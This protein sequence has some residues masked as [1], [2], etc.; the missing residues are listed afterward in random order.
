[1]GTFMDG[2]KRHLSIY[3][4][5]GNA[6]DLKPDTMINKQP[7]RRCWHKIVKR[8]RIALCKEAIYQLAPGAAPKAW[9]TAA[10][11]IDRSVGSSSGQWSV[12]TYASR[13]V[14]KN[15]KKAAEV[16]TNIGQ[17]KQL[18][19]E[20]EAGIEAG[21]VT[22]P[23]KKAV[24]KAAKKS[25]PRRQRGS[26]RKP[27]SRRPGVR[28]GIG[29]GAAHR[30]LKEY[31][32]DNPLSVGIKRKGAKAETE[33]DLPSGDRIDV[34]F[35][36]GTS[37]VGVEVKSEQSSEDDIRR[38]LYQCVKYRAVMEADCAV[39]NIEKNI[40]VLLALGGPFPQSLLREKTVL[41]IEVRDEMTVPN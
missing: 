13:L 24:S 33:K 30:T 27:G 34:F 15:K 39:R 31:I 35:E 11:N 10:E 38:G 7:A 21:D 32:R 40:R 25:G 1:M 36:N 4:H 17:I 3:S 9:E 2:L 22:R 12:E 20:L 6:F 14:V 5:N 37:W 26:G 8:A 19:F 16:A 28:G 23:A 41:D 29:E 18:F